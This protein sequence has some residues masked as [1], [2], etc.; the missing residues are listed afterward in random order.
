VGDG[1]FIIPDPDQFYDNTS[2]LAQT[3][4]NSNRLGSGRA[5]ALTDA[6]T[7][8]PPGPTIKRT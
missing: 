3:D 5:T 7:S 8:T 4:L 2:E 1:R 6:S